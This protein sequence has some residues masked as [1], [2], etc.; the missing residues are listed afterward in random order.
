MAR[1]LLSLEVTGSKGG[2]MKINC[3]CCGRDVN[4]DHSVFED[5][6]GPVKCFS[7]SAM[8]EVKSVRGFVDSILPLQ[9]L[10][11]NMVSAGRPWSNNRIGEDKALTIIAR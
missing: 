7:C 4:L 10:Q 6:E 11:Q 8:M 1:A 9:R 3:I 2:A 5:Y